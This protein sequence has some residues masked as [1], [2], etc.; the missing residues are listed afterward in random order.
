MNNHKR[1]VIPRLRKSARG[2][3]CTMNVAQVCTYINDTTVLAH[4]NTEGGGVGLKT[5]DFSAVFCCSECHQW[6]DQYMGTEEDRLFY[7]LR[8]LT[9]T[10]RIMH[11]QGLIKI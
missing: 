5:D 10:H 8:A 6:L 2:Q 11:S 3:S 7:Q 9:R 4:I 1:A